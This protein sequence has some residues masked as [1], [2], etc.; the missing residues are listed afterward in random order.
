MTISPPSEALSDRAGTIDL[1]VL[2]A[3]AGGVEALTT[4]AAMLPGDLDAAV[5]VVLHVSEAGTSVMPEI[6]S[7]SGPL[8]AHSAVDGEL[9]EAGRIYVA[10]PA[11]HL[12]VEGNRA[13]VDQ[14]PRENG[15]R[16]AIDPLMRAAGQAFGERAAGVVLSGA[17]D[18]STA[19]L[20]QLKQRGGVAIAQDPATALYPSMPT[21]A[22]AH[23]PLDAVLPLTEVAGALRL[24]AGQRRSNAGG[25]GGLVADAHPHHQIPTQE[26]SSTRFTCPD[27]GGVLSEYQNGSLQRYRCSVGH[28]YSFDSLVEEQSHQL[29]SALWAAVRT[30][31]D[32][33]LLLRRMEHDALAR[34][35][36]RAAG[37]FEQ[38]AV[39]AAEQATAIRGVIA[40]GGAGASA[41]PH[42]TAGAA[43]AISE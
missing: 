12:T 15:H 43:E 39:L 11:H 33:A 34:G 30:L 13:R 6:L 27:C 16:P 14:G 23:V 41:L 36:D 7:R 26:G 1:I 2:G 24:L 10:P 37:A 42:A 9:L 19:G 21:N 3:S 32:R 20:L 8:P 4:V 29:E 35:N 22:I 25:G 31:E 5:L 17:R 40:A 38:R 28:A 18:D